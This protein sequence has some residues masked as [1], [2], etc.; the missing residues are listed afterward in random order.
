MVQILLIAPDAFLWMPVHS[1]QHHLNIQLNMKKLNSNRSFCAAHI[2]TS[3]AHLQTYLACSFSLGCGAEVLSKFVS[4]SL[5]YYVVCPFACI[6]PHAAFVANPSFFTAY[7]QWL[8]TWL[9]APFQKKAT[10]GGVFFFL[11]FWG[12]GDNVYK[13]HTIAA[14]KWT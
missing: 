11:F 14:K 1:G 5:L 4:S 12:G 10:S 3:S 2:S 9:Y 6:H 7:F 8:N 13:K